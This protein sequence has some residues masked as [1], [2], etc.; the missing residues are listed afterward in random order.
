VVLK[1]TATPYPVIFRFKDEEGF[2]NPT[3]G[4][5]EKFSKLEDPPTLDLSI[6]IPAYDEEKRCESIIPR[7]L[8]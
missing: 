2:E 5:K 1:I 3:T 7:I 4:K 6:I 8:S